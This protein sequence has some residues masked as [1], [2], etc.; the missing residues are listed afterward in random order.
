LKTSDSSRVEAFNATLP[1]ISPKKYRRRKIK[2][3]A[4]D[5]GR[6]LRDSTISS[7]STISARRP[8]TLRPPLARLTSI[9]APPRSPRASHDLRAHIGGSP[10]PGLERRPRRCFG[11]PPAGS[12][13]PRRNDG[14]GT[15]Q[16]LGPRGKAE[17]QTWSRIHPWKTAVLIPPPSQPTR[18]KRARRTCCPW[19]RRG[20]LLP[21]AAPNAIHSTSVQHRR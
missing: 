7:P 9:F 12:G 1:S 16:C 17:T 18:F 4:E 15:R 3:T 19:P 8:Q 21:A 5:T 14:K 10:A 13:R 11:P 2:E 6:Y 20:A